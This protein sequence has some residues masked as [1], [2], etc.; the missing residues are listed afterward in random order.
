MTSV[1]VVSGISALTRINGIGNAS[2]VEILCNLA[3][4]YRFSTFFFVIGRRTFSEL[5]NLTVNL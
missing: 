5:L 3:A 2:L 4:C 1:A